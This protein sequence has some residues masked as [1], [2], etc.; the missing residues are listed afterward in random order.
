MSS[1]L[2]LC[3]LLSASA[4]LLETM[5]VA[6]WCSTLK[7]K[8]YSTL[9]NNDVCIH[10]YT[11]SDM[12]A[13]LTKGLFFVEMSFYKKGCMQWL[14]FFSKPLLY[15][16]LLIWFLRLHFYNKFYSYG[17]ILQVWLITT[18]GTKLDKCSSKT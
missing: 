4:F 2:D 17:A 12:A 10:Q 5:H 8:N 9:Q 18:S 13:A 7:R 6:Q 14:H 3:P 15:L 1:F 11:V 16:M